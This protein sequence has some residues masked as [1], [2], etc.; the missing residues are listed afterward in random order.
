M[1]CQFDHF[2]CYPLGERRN[3]T[4]GAFALRVSFCLLF[5][6]GS[7]AFQ[8]PVFGLSRRSPLRRATAGLHRSPDTPK[9]VLA[10]A[11]HLWLF[12]TITSVIVS[13]FRATV[14]R[15]AVFE[16]R[17]WISMQ[18]VSYTRYNHVRKSCLVPPRY[19]GRFC[20]HAPT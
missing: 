2:S 7:E 10:D 5:L 8:L 6:S 17:V 20:A 9:T 1:R 14:V 4:R 18:C 11:Q 12:F 19:C 16:P 3:E 13:N 15:K